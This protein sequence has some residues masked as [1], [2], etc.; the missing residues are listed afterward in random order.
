[1]STASSTPNNLMPNPPNAREQPSWSSE[2]AR[3]VNADLRENQRVNQTRSAPL[4]RIIDNVDRAAHHPRGANDSWQPRT[5]R[6]FI[7]VC[8][9]AVLVTAALIGAMLAIAKNTKGGLQLDSSSMTESSTFIDVKSDPKTTSSFTDSAS[10]PWSTAITTSEDFTTVDSAVSTKHG[11]TASS[12]SLQID[13]SSFSSSGRSTPSRLIQSSTTTTEKS[14]SSSIDAS[15]GLSAATTS[16]HEQIVSTSTLESLVMIPPESA[17]TAPAISSELLQTTAAQ[18]SQSYSST[19][20][21]T[22]SVSSDNITAIQSTADDTTT[23]SLPSA[24]L[25]A[26]RTT[27]VGRSD[28]GGQHRSTQRFHG[29][30][31]RERV[32]G[33]RASQE[34]DHHRHQGHSGRQ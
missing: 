30:A 31:T 12:Q 6:C 32:G 29:P 16:T 21:S 3:K 10:N 33:Q 9:A 8:L 23:N 11:P 2:F 25:S 34:P 22:A 14:L 27:V 17:L 26:S 5:I 1:M 18:L 28:Q 13:S 7:A 19:G 20:L 15:H 24:T 4:I